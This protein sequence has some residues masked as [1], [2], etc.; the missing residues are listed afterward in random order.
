MVHSF[1]LNRPEVKSNSP[2]GW[3][4]CFAVRDSSG[5][6]TR[7]A[8]VSLARIG[9]S[10]TLALRGEALAASGQARRL[11]YGWRPLLVIAAPGPARTLSSAAR[12][13][14][15]GTAPASRRG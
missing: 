10:E 7:R 13:S 6:P 9:A 4:G 8:S 15:A 2:K 11:P 14:A 12:P 5:P 1:H 3:I